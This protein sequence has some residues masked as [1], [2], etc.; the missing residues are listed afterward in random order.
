MLELEN[1]LISAFAARKSLEEQARQALLQATELLSCASL[2]A[3]NRLTAHCDPRALLLARLRKTQFELAQARDEARILRSRIERITARERPHYAPE[4]R[5][6]ILCFKHRYLLSAADAARRF[7][8]S[9]Q[10]I[11]PWEEEAREHPERDTVGSLLRP[12]PPIT[13]MRDV[14]RELVRDMKLHGF[15]G[16][17]MV[18]QVVTRAVWKVSARSVGRFWKERVPAPPSSRRRHRPRPIH[19][20]HVHDVFVLDLTDIPTLFRS[21]PS[22]CA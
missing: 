2:L 3:L 14:V 5:F 1:R 19:A 18:A 15:G 16:N 22:S 7:A 11:L 10:T 12:V 4:I 6:Q 17:R 8:V 20:R 13:R 21:S 9:I